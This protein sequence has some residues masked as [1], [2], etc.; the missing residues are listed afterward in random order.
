MSYDP[1]PLPA[2]FA[3]AFASARERF[4]RLGTPLLFFS[5][6][7]S[8]NDVA[9]A[10]ASRGNAGAVVVADMQ[11]AGRGR[12]GRTWFSPPGAGLYV[13]VILEPGRAA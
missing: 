7:E 8:T 13:S 12:R 10:L 9:S 6:T 4:G 2:D 11:T 1:E 3:D 5:T